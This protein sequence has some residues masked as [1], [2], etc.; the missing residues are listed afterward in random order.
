ML[1]SHNETDL[2]ELL[3]NA[4]VIA[5]V[6]H[7]ERP[8]RTS[9]QIAVYLRHAGYKVYPVNP[10][11]S[12]IDGEI[13]YPSLSEVPEPIDIVNVFRRSQFL[14]DVVEQAAAVKAKAVWAQLGVE[15]A[16]AAAAAEA[17]HLPLVMDM[18]IKVEHRRLL[19]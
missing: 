15:S 9:Y 14:A 19:G 17:A 5:V 6:G 2:R 3:A 7:S 13:C 12:S 8:Y 18:C 16:E 1:I 10:E 11:V 4:R